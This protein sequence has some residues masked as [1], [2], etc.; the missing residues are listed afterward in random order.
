MNRFEAYEK[1]EEEY[2]YRAVKN[3]S[4]V[5]VAI[6]SILISLVVMLIVISAMGICSLLMDANLWK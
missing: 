6:K 1:D 2:Q 4:T 3:Y 5:S